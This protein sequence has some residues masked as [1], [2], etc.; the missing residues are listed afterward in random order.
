MHAQT[1]ALDAR[2]L[3][4]LFRLDGKVALVAGGYGGIGEA[5]SWALAA[6]GATVAISGRSL[7]RASALAVSLAEAGHS[8]YAAKFDILDVGSIRRHV[9]EVTQTLG[10]VDILVNC[11]GAQREERAEEVS[12]E[13][14]DHVSDV[15]LKGAFF[16]AQAAGRHQLRAGGGRQIHL[17]SVRSQ[18][19]LRGRGYAPYC[20]TKGGL[21][22]LVK[23]LAAEWAPHQILVNG[24]APTF[25]RTEFVRSY[26]EDEEF[27]AGL[28]SRIPLQ[29]IA[30][31]LD[32]AGA[33]LFLAGPASSFITGQILFVDGGITA[34]Q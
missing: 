2:Q 27:Y 20:G 33:A 11:V 1:T 30:D 23:Q 7:V 31:P 4:S 29:R 14:W 22:L 25:T 6:Y 16:L 34:T 10:R 24:I 18:L 9:D 12:E 13:T 19:A 17:S 15:N 28:V 8:A 26:L 3:A 32:C 21:N 5:I